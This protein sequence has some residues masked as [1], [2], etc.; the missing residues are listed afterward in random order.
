MSRT[1]GRV[2]TVEVEMESLA[3]TYLVVAT[4]IMA[5]W[6]GLIGWGLWTFLG[7]MLFG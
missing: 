2:A 3:L 6:L 1:L 4:I 7:S 5:C